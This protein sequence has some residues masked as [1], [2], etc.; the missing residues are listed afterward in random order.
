MG[1]LGSTVV[2]FTSHRHNLKHRMMGLRH[3]IAATVGF[4]AA[5]IV[6]YDIP[7]YDQVGDD[8]GYHH[9]LADNAAAA[10]GPVAVQYAAPVPVLG[11][12]TPQ[13][14]RKIARKLRK[15]SYSE[16]VNGGAPVYL[17]A[18]MEHL[19]REALGVAGNSALD[20]DKTKITAKHITSQLDIWN[21]AEE[22]NESGKAKKEQSSFL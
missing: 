22:T 8:T 20:D 16:R 6:A 2:R 12:G 15:G 4:F 13:F 21:T 18:V 1:S 10:S 11:G 17:A 3:L 7:A 19:V 5:S 14:R 9:P